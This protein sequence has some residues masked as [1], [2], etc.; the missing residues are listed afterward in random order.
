M[1]DQN[2]SYHWLDDDGPAFGSP[3]LEPRWTSSS[4]DAVVTAYAASSRVWFTLSHGI[5]NEIYYPT[6]DR[7]QTRDMEL[8]FSDGETFFHEEKRDLEYDFEYMDPAAPAVRVRATDTRGLYTVTKEFV[9]DPHHPV[10]LMHVKLEGEDAVLSRL[11]CYALLAP[12]LNVGGWG[13]SARSVDMAGKRCLL[14]WK[15]GVS[16]AMGADCGFTASSCGYVG[17][18]DGYQDVAQHL[19]MDWHF[20]QALN[21]NIAVMGEI[22]IAQHPEFTIAIAFGEGP[23]A[24]V[25]QMKQ[26]LASD[27]GEHRDRF[28]AQWQRAAP[29]DRLAA[30]STDKGRLARISHKLLLTHEDKTFSG[31]FI[32]SA[33]I[34]WG[35]SKSD[36][37]LGGYHLVWTRDM[38]QTATALLECG[39]TDEALHPGRASTA[40]RALVYLACTQR[41]DGSFAQNFWI[42]GTPYW[43]GIQLDEV[44]FPIMLAWRLWKMDGLGKFD[45]VPF[46]ERAASFL[47]RYAPITQQERWEE[48]AG[49]SPST[50]AA[51]ISGL[52]CAADI[53]RA[54][55][56]EEQA[57]FLESYADWIEAHLDEWT[58]TDEGVLHPQIKRHYMRIRPPAPGEPF[59]NNDIPVGSVQINNR[60]PGEKSV[61]EAR[62]IIDAGFLELVR[63]GIRRADDPLI[64]DSLKVVDYCLKSESPYGPCWRRYNHD[65]YGERKDGGPYEGWG[66][67]RSWPL[68]A[69]ERAHYELAAGRDVK[70]LITALEQFS[71]RGGMLPEQVW[72]TADMPQCGMFRGRPA[73]S[74]QPLVWAHSEY[75]KLLCSVT[76]RAV[77]DRISVVERRYAV[78]KDKRTFANHTEIFQLTRPVTSI[79]AGHTL[80]IVD[81][82]RFRVVY[83]MDGWATTLSTDSHTVGNPGFVANIPIAAGQTGSLV[84]TLCWVDQNGERWLG[85]NIDVSIVPGITYRTASS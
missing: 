80:R 26:S 69:G 19:K 61:F 55:G 68:L 57:E 41:P 63:Y 48:A 60:E 51:V 58:T 7:P 28:I 21:G 29:V 37:D 64:V 23:H 32:A 24:A 33:S 65:G 42:D 22:D 11:K 49:Y 25:A 16:L 76:N 6:I 34:P 74:A 83:S 71:S 4:K 66:Q 2:P 8:L 62:E 84:F 36:V 44:A 67:G 52:I 78:P 59:H 85:R 54:R 35:A 14:A 17:A 12:H 20:G 9:A 3:G 81:A 31:A 47:V 46:V 53:M 15:D 72:D 77:M 38:V 30:A 56:S 40:L 75:L 27:F 10:V 18:S 1:S 5:L 50:L 39:C 70:P 79:P 82:G 43:S 45:I 73:G 13:N